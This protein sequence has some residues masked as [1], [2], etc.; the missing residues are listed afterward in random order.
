[1]SD[2]LTLQSACLQKADEIAAMIKNMDLELAAGVLLALPSGLSAAVLSSKLLKKELQALLLHAMST[3]TIPDSSKHVHLLSPEAKEAM[4]RRKENAAAAAAAAATADAA[5]AVIAA[6]ESAKD[7]IW[8]A[9]REREEERVAEQK[10]VEAIYRA[11]A[12]RKR[13][14][15]EAAV[16]KEKEAEAVRARRSYTEKEYSF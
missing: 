11:A 7:E 10:H 9:E 1:M 3:G 15:E 13:A 4:A 2:F 8:S 14:E 6:A 16:L 12:A 5:A